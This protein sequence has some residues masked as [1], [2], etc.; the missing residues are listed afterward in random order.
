MGNLGR[1]A[2]IDIGSNSV[3]LVVLQRREGGSV[4]MLADSRAALRLVRS[5]DAR[6]RLR[7]EAIDRTIATLLDFKAITQGMGVR[8]RAQGDAYWIKLTVPF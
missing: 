2:V 5:I 8:N 4:E 7:R 3:R 6:G 1:L